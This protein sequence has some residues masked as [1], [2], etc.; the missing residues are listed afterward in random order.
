MNRKDLIA[1][2]KQ[3]KS[4]LCVGLDTDITKL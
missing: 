2:I 1:Q 3:K 4:Y